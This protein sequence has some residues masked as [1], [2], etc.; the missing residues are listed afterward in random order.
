MNTA[1]L[2]IYMYICIFIFLNTI[3]LSALIYGG[4]QMLKK[5]D[6]TENEIYNICFFIFCIASILGISILYSFILSYPYI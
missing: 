3:L 1:I 2:F 5:Y 4:K 6:E